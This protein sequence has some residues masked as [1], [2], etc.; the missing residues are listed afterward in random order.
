MFFFFILN[1][2]SDLD[3]SSIWTNRKSDWWRY[4][5]AER[6][7]EMKCYSTAHAHQTLIYTSLANHATIRLSPPVTLYWDYIL[8]TVLRLSLIVTFKRIQKNIYR[9]KQSSYLVVFNSTAR[10][11][12]FVASFRVFCSK[13]HCRQ[14]VFLQLLL[15]TERVFLPNCIRQLQISFWTLWR[16]DD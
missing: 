10:L 12:Q 9:F 1:P 14:E 7:T 2:P 8:L 11:I 15:C 5:T 16:M 6:V 13:T 3:C 4:W